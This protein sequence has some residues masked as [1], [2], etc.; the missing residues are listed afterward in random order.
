MACI[1]VFYPSAT[2]RCNLLVDYM[3]QYVQGKLSAFE[4]SVL[5]LLLKRISNPSALIQLLDEQ[6]KGPSAV[7]GSASLDLFNSILDISR[8]EAEAALDTCSSE[9]A[10]DQPGD[11][12]AG[13]GGIGRS[14]VSMLSSLVKQL[15]SQAVQALGLAAEKAGAAEP[16]S[17]KEAAPQA[18]VDVTVLLHIFSRLS[19]T[20]TQLLDRAVDAAHTLAVPALPRADASPT[21]RGG[22]SSIAGLRQPTLTRELDGLL[23]ASPVGAL[24]P[25]AVF[26]VM[27][28]V[29]YQSSALISALGPL[30]KALAPLIERVRRATDLL[31]ADKRPSAARA[32]VEATPRKKVAT[33]ESAHPYASNTNETIIL[34]M[35]RAERIT[36]VFDSQSATE[37][38]YDYL[39]FW[40]DD[41]RSERWHPEEKLTGR[42]GSENWPGC[43]GRPPLVIEGDS[44]VIQWMSDGSNEDWGWRFT[45]TAEFKK[46]VVPEDQHW[47]VSLDRHLNA[48]GAALAKGLTVSVEWGGELEERNIVWMEDET[49][50]SYSSSSSSGPHRPSPL[51]SPPSSTV[52]E[53]PQQPVPTP[54]DGPAPLSVQT[55]ASRLLSSTP[56]TGLSPRRGGTTRGDFLDPEVEA[57]FLQSIV[58]RPGPD[59]LGAKL[60]QKMR[61]RVMED[62]GQYESID[63][64]VYASMAAIIKVHTHTRLHTY[65]HHSRPPWSSTWLTLCLSLCGAGV[66]VCR[67]ISTTGWRRRRTRW[68][69]SRGRTCPSLC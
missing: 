61:G 56:P 20:S 41:T 54:K 5:G 42:N 45:A 33:F 65:P 14:A 31:P 29:R 7:G 26:V 24:L 19:E 25:L 43:G 68:P 4:A 23:Q 35:P 46:T 22:A 37:R 60:V 17:S 44:A 59:S 49:I 16:G 21:K 52:T 36:I 32:S 67:P 58:T 62:R 28:L 1:D 39:I 40:K 55:A 66:H 64:A 12:G 15:L 30:S 3:T 50:S 11:E 63:N 57:S 2:Q 6:C 69:V 34:S 13:R 9:D 53:Q 38:D 8:T 48:C 51:P 18:A 27:E 10:A 47:L